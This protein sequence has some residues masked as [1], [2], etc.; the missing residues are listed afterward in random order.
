[1]CGALLCGLAY[2]YSGNL[3][4]TYLGEVIGTGLL[5]ALLAYPVALFLIGNKTA[6]LF[7]FVIPF[8]VSTLGGTVIAAMI[9]VALKKTKL[10]TD[11]Q[12]GA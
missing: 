11:V 12:L 5:G 8:S 2:K 4:A 7:M 3:Y 9:V 10:L 6:V 1:M